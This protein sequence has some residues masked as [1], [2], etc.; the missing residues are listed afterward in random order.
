[1]IT[2]NILICDEF[3]LINIGMKIVIKQKHPYCKYT[4]PIILQML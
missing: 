2:H 1:M 4:E 3:P